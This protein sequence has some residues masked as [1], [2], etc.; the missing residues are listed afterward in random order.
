[1]VKKDLWE[2]CMKINKEQLEAMAALPDDVLWAEIVAIAA[3]Y[4]VTLPRETPRHNDLEKL[5]GAVTGSK[6]NMSDAL[7]VLNSYRRGCGK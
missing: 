6:L 7:R 5:R 4:G 1:M 3:G 2:V